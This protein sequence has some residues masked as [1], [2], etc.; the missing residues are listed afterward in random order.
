MST[1]DGVHRS[2]ASP[3]GENGMVAPG[4]DKTQATPTVPCKDT[5]D[6]TAFQRAITDAGLASDAPAATNCTTKVQ[7][8][9]KG[10]DAQGSS[11]P[12]SE[13]TPS[14]PNSNESE[15]IKSTM[16]IGSDK[17]PKTKEDNWEFI[18]HFVDH[19]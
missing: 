5:A 11:S 1:P 15:S 3:D 18:K 10:H 6:Y 12:G 9:T 19:R 16:T 8:K 2:Q 7:P 17:K 14:Q 4:L 13:K